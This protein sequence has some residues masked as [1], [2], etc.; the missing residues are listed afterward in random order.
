MGL[1]RREVGV[2][3]ERLAADFLEELG[4]QIVQRNFRCKEGEID[5]IAQQGECLVFVEVRTRRGSAFGTPEESIT[6]SKGERLVSVAESYLQTCDEQPA[7]WRIDVV[8]V[9]LSSNNEIV[10]LGHIENAIG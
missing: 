5:I 2:T 9:E 1:T 6:Q 10:R 3:G 7:S 8:A 4:Y